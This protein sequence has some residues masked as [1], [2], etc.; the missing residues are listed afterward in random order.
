MT[1]KNI[2]VEKGNMKADMVAAVEPSA[3]AGSHIIKSNCMTNGEEEKS[4]YSSPS[5]LVHNIDNVNYPYLWAK[6]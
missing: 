4:S 2:L 6:G 5:F 1:S 3:T